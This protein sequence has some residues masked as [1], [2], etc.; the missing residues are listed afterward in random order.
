MADMELTPDEEKQLEGF[1]DPDQPSS[2]MQYQ[3]DEEFQ[4]ELLA[5]LLK[6]H[7]FTVQSLGLVQSDYFTHEVHKLLGKL[8]FKYFEK[9]KQIPPKSTMG[10]LLEEA[11]KSKKLEVKQFYRQE[12]NLVYDYYHPRIESRDFI[13][14]KIVKF[15]QRTA[16]KAAFGTCGR[17][18]REKGDEEEA[19]D[20]VRE[21][22]RKAMLVERDTGLG[23]DYFDNVSARL[24]EM[25]KKHDPESAFTTGFKF[26]DDAL[27]SKG[28][29]RGEIGSWMGLSGTGKSLA[30]VLASIQNMHKGHKVLY[31]SL[32]LDQLAVAERFDAQL[33]DPGRKHGI[34]IDNLLLKENEAVIVQ[35]LNDYLEDVKFE[36]DRQRL[37]V[38][39]FPGGELSVSDFRAYYARAVMHGFKPDLVIIDYVGEMK[40]YPKMPEWQSKYR[41]VRDLRGFAVAEQVCVLTAMQPNKSAKLVLKEGGMI[42]DENLADAYGQ[43]KPLDAFWTLNQTRDERD[44]GIGRGL[45]VKH[46][47]GKSGKHFFLEIDRDTLEIRQISEENYKKSKLRYEQELEVSTSE[48]TQK[49]L[50]AQAR[51]K[52]FKERGIVAGLRALDKPKTEEDKAMAAL[53]ASTL[54][55]ETDGIV[56]PVDPDDIQEQVQREF[57]GED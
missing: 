34:T 16:I 31:I 54:D 36:G 22:L 21:H 28:L 40:D 38:K 29:N 45:I 55:C 5:T 53:A 56:K 33:S 41:I 35:S 18:L 6:D 19:I 50:E 7:H 46:R 49:A 30:L 32:E 37:I 13:L 42:D 10:V 17:I 23:L 47:H 12:F 25:R 14:D 44:I 4:K 51:V 57:N 24:E 20:E 9:Y 11:I 1:I 15:A 52:F 26:I 48:H 3:W 39:Q 27:M 2:E 8:L 43:I